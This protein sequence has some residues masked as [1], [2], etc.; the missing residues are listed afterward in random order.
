MD[1]KDKLSALILIAGE[2][3]RIS[4]YTNSPKCL[5]KI[6]GKSLLRRN[7][8]FLNDIGIINIFIVVGF[9]Y[10]LIL[11]E[12]KKIRKKLNV[13]IIY[14]RRYKTHG[15]CFSLKL[16]L[17]KIKD[18]VIFFDGDVVYKKDILNNYIRDKNSNSVLIGKGNEHDIEC[19]KVFGTKKKV[20]RII[21]KRIFH[22]KSHIFLGEA[23]GINKLN[24]VQINKFLNIG[25]KIFKKKSNLNLNWDTFYD[26]YFLNN[27]AIKY[28]KT[29]SNCWVEIDT[30][31]DYKRAKK[32]IR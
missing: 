27:S 24:K 17:E 30:I 25:K 32:I 9:K 1:K 11:E 4:Q 16:G 22:E 29:F 6:K 3:N 14:N 20:K 26:K 5:L 31:E 7:L 15:N 2:G 19:A 18:S 13:T 10:K 8:E 28:S 23:I 12:I 21:E